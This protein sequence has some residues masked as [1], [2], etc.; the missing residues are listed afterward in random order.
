MPYTHTIEGRIIHIAWSGRITKDDLAKLGR[1]LPQIAGKLHF[2]P[3]VLHTYDDS[4]E[5]GFEL[6]KIH[7]YST[8]AKQVPPPVPIRS[9]MVNATMQGEYVATL[10]KMLNRVE[11]IEMRVFCDEASARLWLDEHQPAQA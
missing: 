7:H 9:A 3:N 5:L 11:N 2:A 4:I 8:V 6:T 1:E 10:F